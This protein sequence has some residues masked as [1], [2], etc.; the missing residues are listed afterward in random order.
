[1]TLEDT[2]VVCREVD[3][4]TGKIAVYQIK[5]SVTDELI[6]KLEIRARINPE[7]QY[8]V[9]TIEEYEDG[10]AR[11]FLLDPEMDDSDCGLFGVVKI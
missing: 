11:Q 9:T 3:K 6:F 2:I 1:M 5:A 8:F 4:N 7:L 10:M